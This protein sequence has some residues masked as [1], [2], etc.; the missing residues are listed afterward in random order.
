[1]PKMW[2]EDKTAYTAKEL[3]EAHPV[4]F[5]NARDEYAQNSDML[6][7]RCEEGV[8]DFTE[9]I[10][11]ALGL[12]LADEKRAIAYSIGNYDG[13]DY[14]ALGT[15][16]SVSDWPTFLL[17]LDGHP[18]AQIAPDATEGARRVHIDKR[19][20][21][22]RALRGGDAYLTFAGVKNWRGDVERSEAG[23]E[24]DDYSYY[25]DGLDA[26]TLDKLARQAEA[27]T[28][29]LTDWIDAI[30]QHVAV[31]IMRDIEY[32]TSEEGF[33]DSSESNDW[34]YDEHGHITTPPDNAQEA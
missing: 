9:C 3:L 12:T 4:A 13:T 33:L 15:C 11:P 31:R 5:I 19:S 34:Y 14:T 25:S 29:D 17:A 24:I 18:D 22:Y 10:I 26:A 2:S 30:V 23:I 32:D 1:M 20:A 27:L 7:W 21:I 8:D 6:E 28:A 16:A